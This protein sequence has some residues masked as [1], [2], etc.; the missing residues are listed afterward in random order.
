VD[1]Q[2]Y[3]GVRRRQQ[4]QLY[5]HE[6]L[7]ALATALLGGLLLL[8]QG[9]VAAAQTG[10]RITGNGSTAL[11]AQFAFD[12]QGSDTGANPTGTVH[13]TGPAGSWSA[14]PKC[15]RVRGDRATLGLSID[16]TRGALLWV[17]E[18]A[19]P[20]TVYGRI[21]GR[22]EPIACADPL[23]GPDPSF[24]TFDLSGYIDVQDS[25]PAPPPGTDSVT[26]GAEKCFGYDFDGQCSLF[27]SLAP[28]AV[29]GRLGQDPG[30]AIGFDESG[31]TPG[32]TTRSTA[33][34]TCLSVSGHTAIVGITGSRH[35]YGASE[36]I[37]PYAGL[38]R[39]TDAGGADAHADTVEFAVENG[40]R[41]GPSLPGPTQCSSFPGPFPTGNG[42]FPTFTNASNDLV[43]HDSRS[44]SQARAA[45]IFERVAHGVAAF[46]AKYGRM[47][48]CVRGYMA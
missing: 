9:G 29:S 11:G 36:Q 44:R 40:T 46:K 26:G 31:P 45:C 48:T 6:H 12:V 8:T 20:G 7:Q 42:A 5:Q 17:H 16:A 19:G 30:G 47:R 34:V 43:V 37:I 21:V 4:G 41:N 22:S 13:V 32:A 3:V 38:V 24:A 15:M 18:V 33:A 1:E 14:T 2:G 27:A 28:G 35:R 23:A 39:V 10:D 25:Q